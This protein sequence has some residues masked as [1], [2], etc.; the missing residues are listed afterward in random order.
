MLESLS[1]KHRNVIEFLFFF[2]IC[3]GPVIAPPK[4][5]FGFFRLGSVSWVIRETDWPYNKAS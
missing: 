5:G 1:Q 2:I 4:V 3:K